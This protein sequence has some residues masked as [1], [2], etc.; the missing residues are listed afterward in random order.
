MTMRQHLGLPDL[1]AGW[2][3]AEIAEYLDGREI[4]FFGHAEDDVREIAAV[5]LAIVH[6]YGAVMATGD[7]SIWTRG[8]TDQ[9][10][11]PT[12]PAPP[13]PSGAASPDP[14]ERLKSLIWQLCC[15]EQRADLTVEAL[16]VLD[17]IRKGGQQRPA[18][19]RTLI[20]ALELLEAEEGADFFG[21]YVVD[22]WQEAKRVEAVDPAEAGSSE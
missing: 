17:E 8:A 9:A 6:R 18:L 10:W 11:P 3:V 14:I 2:A 22:A 5:L 20:A 7:L 21:S 19:T 15:Q 4:D 13:P 16:D 12:A 1:L